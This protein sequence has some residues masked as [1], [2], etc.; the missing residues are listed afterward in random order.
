[1]Q[2]LKIGSTTSMAVLAGA[3]AGCGGGDTPPPATSVAPLAAGVATARAANA[4]AA[5]DSASEASA[6]P[7]GAV[8]T[9]LT[10]DAGFARKGS[11][12][13]ATLYDPT[14]TSGNTTHQPRKLKVRVTLNGQPVQ[15]CAVQW[16]PHGN[17]D[18][19]KDRN[20]WVFPDAPATDFNGISSAWWTAGSGRH[21]VLDVDVKRAD[22]S[23]A[24]VAISGEARHH[25][26]RANSI[27]VT[28]NTP[29]WQKFSASVTPHS[30]PGTTY[31]EVIGFNNGYGGIQSQQLL[32]SLWDINGV[33]PV[34]IDSGISTCTTFGGEGT[35]IKCEAA[36][37]PQI[38][39]TYRFELEVAPAP[40][41]QQ[42]YSMYFTD[43]RDGQRKKLGTL[44]SP[45]A[46]PQATAYGFVEDWSDTAHSCLDNPVRAATYSGVRYQGLDGAWVDVNKA[47]GDAVY[48][49]DHNEVCANYRFD[50]AGA[51]S[52]RLS[53]GGH[54]VGQPL[55]LPGVPHALPIPYEPPVAP[56]PLV[57][58]LNVI[59]S[60]GALGSALDD[61]AGSSTPGTALEIYPTHGGASQQWTVAETV[62][63][64]GVYTLI[65]TQSGLA[66]AVAG[67]ATTPGS[68]VSI[69]TPDGTTAQQ[70]RIVQVR[71][72][73][74][75]L[76]HVASGL[77]LD[78]QGGAIG[79]LTPVIIATP[80]SSP[81]QEWSFASLAP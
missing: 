49:P 31:Y 14:I 74:Y 62:A 52:F 46:L 30:W 17:T 18:N 24:T 29:A 37:V 39:A 13:S 61:P 19:D 57:P 59:G 69:E 21:E 54:V 60:Q 16:Q 63:G 32:F 40:N 68:R 78:T 23:R 51:G 73:V 8:L 55:N 28:W 34:V 27:H 79:A 42:D 80:E 12:F 45:S 4:G 64:S 56:A 35:G 3:L 15:G 5:S 72:G 53:T 7:A 26:T 38:D 71:S 67:G 76:I 25:T 1:M 81:T 48:T 22:G 6:C 44:R 33:S 11:V 41:G 10:P 50:D 77:V 2:L 70:W 20:G 47:A 58:G 75:A 36:Y 9:A 43:P 66:L 65:K